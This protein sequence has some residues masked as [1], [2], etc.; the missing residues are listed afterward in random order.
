MEV[1]RGPQGTLFGAGSEGG[2]V[3][4]IT[5]Q[6]SLSQYSGYARSE[7]AFTDGGAPS[8]EVGLAGGGPLIDNEVGFRASAWFRRDGGWIDRVDPTT[9]QILD[10][11]SNSQDSAQARL[12]FTW[13]P[14]DNLHITPSLLYQDLSY[15][16]TSLYWEQLSNPSDNSFLNG[17]VLAQPSTDR[18]TLPALAVDD[19]LG[20]ATLLSNTSFFNRR[21]TGIKDYTN[22]IRSTLGIAPLP[23]IPGENAPV[24][25]EDTQNDITQELRLRSKSDGRLNWVVGLF[26]SHAKQYNVENYIDTYFNQE[27]MGATAGAPFCP[28]AGCNTEQ[29]FGVPL[30][31]GTSV[32]YGAEDTLDVQYAAYTQVDFNATEK[33][34][35]TVGVRAADEEYTNSTYTAGPFAGGENKSG[36]KQ[37]EHPITPKYGISY[38]ADSND[39]LY[40]S[41]AK[42][43]RPGGAN[44]IVSSTCAS[45]LAGLGLQQVPP[46]YNSD[47]V[48]SYE[49]GDKSTV[50][51]GRLQLNA[52]LF[53]IKWEQ[54]QQNI[55]LPTCGSTFTGN[56]GTAVSKGFDLQ[57]Q[58][59]PIDPWLVQLN[60][61]FTDAEYTETVHGGANAI[62]AEQ[63]ES[64]LGISKWSGTLSSQYDFKIGDLKSY[65]RA[66]YE[67]IGTGAPQD[68]RVYGYDP[69]LYPTPQETKRLSLRLGTLINDWNISLFVDNVTN[70]EPVLSRGHDTLSS[71]I[72]TAY[73]Y[74]PRTI[75][76]TAIYRY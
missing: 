67:F 26:Y 53:W 32:F 34:K 18:L 14:I 24:D 76:L 54:I 55:V 5:P 33:L 23:T 28:P 20:F 56:L 16:D 65:G 59:R 73:T 75:G 70:D 4:F 3:R 48:W 36:G 22:W 12:A 42:G 25:M 7:L 29:L 62:I 11:N 64:I 51:N 13:M 15:Q 39:L 35:L 49:I 17:R 8:Y 30:F 43:F 1:L 57:A 9:L 46:S 38:Q 41:A 66:D 71:P 68:P 45:D 74:R 10:R 63:G 6:P 72:F 69:A 44:I 2:A 37:V 58:F 52:S 40:A 60:G 31:N 61:G 50:A 19:D 27:V 47:H 21:A